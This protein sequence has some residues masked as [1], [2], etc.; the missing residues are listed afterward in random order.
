VPTWSADHSAHATTPARPGP[1]R[2]HTYSDLGN[3]EGFIEAFPNNLR[4]LPERN[5]WLVW[6]ERR[7]RWRRDALRE[8][9]AA[10]KGMDAHFAQDGG[11][12]RAG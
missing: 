7:G 12:D 11:G 3:A 6:D 4:F 10:A 5:V 9:E 8:V 2:P 1:F